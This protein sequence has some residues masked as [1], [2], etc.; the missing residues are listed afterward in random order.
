[1]KQY[2]LLLISTISALL[3]ACGDGKIPT[4]TEPL[5][6][7]HAAYVTGRPVVDGSGNEQVWQNSRPFIVHIE[8][9]EAPKVEFNV[10]FKAIWW[11]E[12]AKGATAWEEKAF[13]ALLANWPDDDKNIDK[14]AW[15]FDPAS[16]HWSRTNQKSDWLLLRWFSLSE[17]SDLWYWDAA[18]TNPL[19]YAEDQ[20]LQS[21][22][23]SDSTTKSII[24]IDGLN[25]N[26]DTATEQNTW[27]LNYD[28]NL[29]PRDSSDDKPKWAWKVATPS[30]PRVVT[31]E[32]ERHHFLLSGDIDFLRNTPYAKPTAAVTIPGYALE[33]PKDEPADI[34]A[35]GKWANGEWTLELVRAAATPYANDVAFDYKDR[36]F[37]QVFYVYVG[38]DEKSPLDLGSSSISLF[39][40]RIVLSLEFVASTN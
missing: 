19:G 20:Y 10:T 14:N 12:W 8:K 11:K 21:M 33:E 3:F 23:M 17:L 15:S 30:L 25:F 2:L 18:I 36:W 39:M 27:D 1:M 40:N 24:W 6:E 16:S 5:Q 4:A 35:A 31:S 26:N 32:E 7:L 37:A 34:M 38:D 9:G 29:T 13:L 22:L 28:D